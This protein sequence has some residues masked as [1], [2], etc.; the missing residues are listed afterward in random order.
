MAI[1]QVCA[2]YLSIIN[3]KLTL[4][5]KSDLQYS[6]IHDVIS[7]VGIIHVD[8]PTDCLDIEQRWRVMTVC[9]PESIDTSS[10]IDMI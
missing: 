10:T 3:D 9:S 6:H 1:I 4:A 5:P 7:D 2:Y 8:P